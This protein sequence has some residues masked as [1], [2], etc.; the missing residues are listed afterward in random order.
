M[1]MDIPSVSK[2]ISENAN[3]PN[4]SGNGERGRTTT[5]RPRATKANKL[6]YPFNRHSGGD[7]TSLGG[8]FFGF[9]GD[10]LAFTFSRSG[11]GWKGN[12]VESTRA[13]REASV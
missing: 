6:M 11:F 13:S 5:A 12:W 4:Q 1:S 3:R 9:E 7:L 2:I 8:D 10:S